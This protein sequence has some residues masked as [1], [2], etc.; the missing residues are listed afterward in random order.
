MDDLALGDAT[1]IKQ[2]K[3]LY[4]AFELFG[5]FATALKLHVIRKWFTPGSFLGVLFTYMIKTCALSHPDSRGYLRHRRPLALL[6]K[7][8]LR[9][10]LP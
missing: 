8:E 7:A 9:L 6:S 1:E 10:R 2:I 5:A 4:Q 3:E